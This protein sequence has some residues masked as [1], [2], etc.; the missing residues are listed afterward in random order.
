MLV[1]R[2]CQRPHADLSGAG[3]RRGSGRWHTAGRPVIYTAYE[4]AL[5]I[6]EVRVNLDLPFELLPDDYVMVGLD[7]STIAVPIP[8]IPDAPA[9]VADSRAIGDAWL[10]SNSSPVLA[11][12]SVLAPRGVN[13][14]INPLHPDAR[15]ITIAVIE[16]FKFDK[17]MWQG[18]RRSP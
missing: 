5:S 16:D 10:I 7:I 13:Y 3:G 8:S 2:L 14:L 12:P 9:D 15:T 6:L 4:P 1:W 17:R 11:V 18:G